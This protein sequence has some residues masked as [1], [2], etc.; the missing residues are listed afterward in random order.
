MNCAFH[1]PP[2]VPGDLLLYPPCRAPPPGDCLA[3]VE[4]VEWT[5]LDAA[6]DGRVEKKKGGQ[7]TADGW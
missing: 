2:L 4:N 1:L 3:S 6:E 5:A 7:E